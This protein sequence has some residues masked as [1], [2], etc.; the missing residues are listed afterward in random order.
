MDAIPMMSHRL[1]G[2]RFTSKSEKAECERVYTKFM[3][4]LK[5]EGID[6]ARRYAE[7]EASTCMDT[8]ATYQN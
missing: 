5:H 7:A 3:H 8:Y 1:P 6:S 4:L 2:F